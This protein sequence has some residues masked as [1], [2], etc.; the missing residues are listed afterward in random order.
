MYA[1]L[2][3]ISSFMNCLGG[4]YLKKGKVCAIKVDWSWKISGEYQ[5]NL[6]GKLAKNPVRKQIASLI[7]MGKCVL[8]KDT[9]K[10]FNDFKNK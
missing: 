9:L 4:I 2:S 3:N 1:Q 10:A 5:V 8:L 6:F 7:N